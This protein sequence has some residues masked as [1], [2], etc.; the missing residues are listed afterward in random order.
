[1]WGNAIEQG[2]LTVYTKWELPKENPITEIVHGMTGGDYEIH[3]ALEYYSIE[4]YSKV[5]SQIDE[6]NVF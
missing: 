2:H 4:L 5:E 6:E 3:H 1:M